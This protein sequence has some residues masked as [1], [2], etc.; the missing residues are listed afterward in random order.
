MLQQC[1]SNYLLIVLKYTK[2]SLRHLPKIFAKMR[3]GRIT[4]SSGKSLG[5]QVRWVR[6]D[7]LM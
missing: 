1:S 3:I 4:D 5:F 7:Q 2:K 6:L